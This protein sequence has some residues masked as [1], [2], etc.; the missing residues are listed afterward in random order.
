MP[1]YLLFLSKL[2]KAKS[3]PKQHGD[4]NCQ[5][6][7]KC[8]ENC[9]RPSFRYIKSVQMFQFLTIPQVK[10]NKK[11]WVIFVSHPAKRCKAKSFAKISWRQFKMLLNTVEIRESL[12]ISST[13][14]GSGCFVGAVNLNEYK[15]GIFR[16]KIIFVI[17]INGGTIPERERRFWRMVCYCNWVISGNNSNV[18]QTSYKQTCSLQSDW[19][20]APL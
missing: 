20:I 17:P 7:Q 10:R 14:F 8:W 11:M 2:A 3:S 15:M 13:K 16:G 1:N 9:F 5:P 6:W 4:G 18:S 12:S 19:T